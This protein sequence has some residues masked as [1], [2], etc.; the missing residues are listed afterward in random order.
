[1]KDAPD[2]QPDSGYCQPPNA[3]LVDQA[4]HSGLSPRAAEAIGEIDLVMSKF[5]RSIQRREF[6]RQI[7]AAVD[8][9]MELSHLDAIAAIAFD[10]GQEGDIEVTVGVLA[11]RMS[12][13]PSRASRLAAEVVERGFVRRVASQADAR[14]ICLQLTRKGKALVDAFYHNKMRIFSAAMGQWT[15]QELTTFAE[16]LGRFSE[17]MTAGRTAGETEEELRKSIAEAEAADR[18]DGGQRDGS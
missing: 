4:R 16:L 8:P 5:R 7:L 6:G 2:T 18:A 1:M 11:E 15:E 13:D 14:R 12:I 3:A 9:T 17:W 10:P